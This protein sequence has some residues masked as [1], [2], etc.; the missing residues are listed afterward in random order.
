MPHY[1]HSGGLIVVGVNFKFK[2]IFKLK[3]KWILNRALQICHFW[4]ILYLNPM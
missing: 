1:E 3:K 2:D 4:T